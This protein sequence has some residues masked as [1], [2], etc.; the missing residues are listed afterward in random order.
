M[1]VNLKHEILGIDDKPIINPQTN[2]P[3]TLQS[4][5]IGA[6]LFPKGRRNPQTGAIEQPEDTDKEKFEKYE[7][8]KRVK[9]VNV[10]V[11]NADTTIELTAEEIS[12]IKKLIHEIEPQ[13]IMGQCWDMLEMGYTKKDKK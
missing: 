3:R 5:I 12:K 10:D 13:L 9:A 2:L 8:Y 11:K 4:V 7:L 6:L 1:I